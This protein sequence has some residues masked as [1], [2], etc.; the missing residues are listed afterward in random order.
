MLLHLDSIADGNLPKVQ[1]IPMSERGI[2]MAT[3]EHHIDADVKEGTQARAITFSDMNP[4]SIY[5][6]E[7]N[8]REMSSQQLRDEYLDMLEANLK[9]S[10][11]DVKDMFYENGK[12]NWKLVQDVLLQEA[13]DRRL[14][15][16]FKAAIKYIEAN[17]T[18]ALPV[19]DPVFNE[20]MESLFTSIMRNRIT[21][22]KMAG[23]ALIQASSVG[24]STDLKISFH[25]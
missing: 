11:N 9:E 4:D 5:R 10:F 19:F 17:N 25:G 21:K 16:D 13:V 8:G 14:P 12:F 3:P 6:L 2:Q 15:D 22:Q 23:A 7:G 20:K 18:L 24:L 1:T